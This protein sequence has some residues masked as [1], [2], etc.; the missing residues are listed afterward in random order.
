LSDLNFNVSDAYK[1]SDKQTSDLTF[2]AQ[3]FQLGAKE[4]QAISGKT[5][6]VVTAAGFA[7]ADQ[8]L[9]GFSESEQVSSQKPEP[10]TNQELIAQMKKSYAADMSPAEIKDFLSDKPGLSVEKFKEIMANRVAGQEEVIAQMNPKQLQVVADLADAIKR[11]DDKQIS[12]IL[13]DIPA[14]ITGKIAFVAQYQLQLDGVTKIGV[15]SKNDNGKGYL[16]IKDGNTHMQEKFDRVT[17]Q[18]LGFTSMEIP[19]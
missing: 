8:L 3:S 7:S 12:K 2:A 4:M 6:D 16:I 5:T 17:G 18:H 1:P 14:D 15:E 19:M 11:N 13:Q 10:A 9:A